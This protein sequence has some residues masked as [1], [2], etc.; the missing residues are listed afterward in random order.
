MWKIDI[1]D[2]NVYGDVI[3]L[4]PE[5]HDMLQVMDMG[6]KKHGKDSW[7]DADN[8][9]LQLKANHASISRHLAEYYCGVQEDH[10]SGLDPLLHI[11]TRA[12]MEYT[13]RQRRITND[14]TAQT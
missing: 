1:D 10:E 13:R 11:A 14:E 3:E 9:S 7:L 4:P 5:F 12:L 8:P 6:N 2:S